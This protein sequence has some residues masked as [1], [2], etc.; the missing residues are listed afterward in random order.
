MFAINDKVTIA[1]ARYTILDKIGSGGQGAV[2]KIKR[3]GSSDCYALKIINES[4][5]YVRHN[6]LS[7]I[8]DIIAARLNDKL[9]MLGA[10]EG[11]NHVCPIAKYSEKGKEGYIMDCVQGATLDSMLKDGSIQRMTI[12]DKLVLLRKLARAIEIFHDNGWIYADIN[13]GNFMWDAKTKTLHVLDCENATQTVCIASGERRFVRG[14]GFFMAPE[15]AF[16]VA[17]VSYE[18]DKYAL[19]TML[20]RV[21]T[22]NNL[23]SAYHGAAMYS[24][25]PACQNMMDVAECE[26][27]G[28]ID[29]NWR[30]FVFDPNNTSNGIATLF[31]NAKNEDAKLQR[32]GF[33]EAISIWASLDNRLKELFCKAFADPFAINSRPIPAQWIRAIDGILGQNTPKVG[34]CQ[35]APQQVQ[36]APVQAPKSSTARLVGLGNKSVAITRDECVVI[37]TDLGLAQ[38]EIGVVRKVGSGYQF[39]SRLMVYVH[40]LDR[41]GAVKDKLS[42]GGKC[43]LSS[44][45]SIKPIISTVAIKIE[46]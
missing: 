20:F 5:P 34:V 23:Q 11:I 3:D 42:M 27:D 43:M 46:Y 14:T 29:V 4:N 31:S 32:R 13:W 30:H 10:K 36:A 22:N 39:E 41:Q 24:A 9:E 6:K 40:V 26:D 33:D 38:K 37:G 45:D 35:V 44:G 8:G 7:N 18:S 12:N 2:W 21:L 16:D 17:N 15:V 25:S 1:G 28:D 19:A